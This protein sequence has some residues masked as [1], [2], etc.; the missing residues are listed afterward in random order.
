MAAGPIPMMFLPIDA[1][2]EP[3]DAF[4]RWLLDRIGPAQVS[5]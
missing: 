4:T 1:D 2:I 5:R 3:R